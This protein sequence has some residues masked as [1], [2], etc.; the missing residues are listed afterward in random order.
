MRWGSSSNP[1]AS[2]RMGGPNKKGHTGMRPRMASVGLA[3][4][5]VIS[6]R[7]RPIRLYA[8]CYSTE[9][10]AETRNLAAV[11]GLLGI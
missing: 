4:P 9:I 11:E 10:A 3:L 7:L 5:S 8:W 1:P 6:R 2:N